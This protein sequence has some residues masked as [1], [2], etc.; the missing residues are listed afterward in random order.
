MT[1]PEDTDQRI[2]VVEDSPTI[3]RVIE[4]CLRHPS[5]QL[6]QRGDGQS[7]LAA[8]RDFEPDLIILDIR[9]PG[10]DGWEVL[11]QLRDSGDG[12]RVSVLVVTAHDDS[13]ARIRART[14]GADGFLAKPFRPADLRQAVDL[15]VDS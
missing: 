15:L 2:L 6:D 1:T 7:A 4:I 10:I 3:Q 9:L 12:K 5:R 13:E 11:R 14:E 8:A